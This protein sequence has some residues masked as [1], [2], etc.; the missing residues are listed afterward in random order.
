[1]DYVAR[2]LACF[3]LLTP[4]ALLADINEDLADQEFY[5][6]FSQTLEQPSYQAESNL[7]VLAEHL[8]ITKSQSDAWNRFKVTLLEQVEKR[9]QLKQQLTELKENK[10]NF[11]S[12]EIIKLRKRLLGRSLNE[13]EQL[14]SVVQALYQVL[15]NHQQPIFDRA[16]K[17]LWLEKIAQYRNPAPITLQ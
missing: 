17:S 13:T 11:S 10:Q 6:F 9:Q 2:L 1:M 12:L 15:N 16:M 3:L 8:Q 4:V 5:Q 14:L 7:A